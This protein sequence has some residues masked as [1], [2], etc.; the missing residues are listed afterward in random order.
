MFFLSVNRLSEEVF[1]KESVNLS[2]DM[3][4]VEWLELLFKL[5]VRRTVEQWNWAAPPVPGGLLRMFAET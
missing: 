5:R 2:W 1:W 3:P 4:E